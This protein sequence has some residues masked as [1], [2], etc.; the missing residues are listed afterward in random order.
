MRLKKEELLE[1]SRAIIDVEQ[2]SR[3]MYEDYLGT[4]EDEEVREILAGILKDEMGHI[5]MAKGLVRVLEE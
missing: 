1:Y 4:I 2:R 3:A 5:E